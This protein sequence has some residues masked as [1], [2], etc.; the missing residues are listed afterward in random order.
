M[1]AA[2]VAS[3][4]SVAMSWP[5]SA[6][7]APPTEASLNE[8]FELFDSARTMD[9]ALAPAIEV[10]KSETDKLVKTAIDSGKLTPAQRAAL[11]QLP[12]KL[13]GMLRA[14]VS[15][16]KFRVQLMRVYGE[17]YEQH[18]V[19]GL[20]AFYK[21]DAGRALGSKSLELLQR[22]KVAITD[23]VAASA[24]RIK[25]EVDKV[26]VGPES[27]SSSS[28]ARLLGHVSAQDPQV[29][30]TRCAPTAGDYPLESRRLEETGTTRIRF[31]VNDTGRL[32]A[33]EI[34]DTSGFP[35]LDIAALSALSTCVFSPGRRADGST[36][37]GAFEV[38]YV[39]K[40]E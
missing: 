18:E 26:L 10:F 35:R 32:V 14:D 31:T 34:V 8:L 1:R 4:C 12:V 11:D 6:L 27:P 16:A 38:K 21:S 9:R 33:F 19:E 7:A 20:I 2:A 24:Y 29:D 30:V 36:H 40:L 5:S 39:W 17:V 37:G 28:K 25:E 3:L 15:W 13:E 22:T 23:M